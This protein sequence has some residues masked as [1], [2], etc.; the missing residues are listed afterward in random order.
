MRLLILMSSN[1]E[2]LIILIQITTV[3]FIRKKGVQLQNILVVELMILS[4]D[5]LNV[6]SVVARVAMGQDSSI[7]DGP[8][9]YKWQ[10]FPG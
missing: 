5:H 10:P 8:R 6:K 1:F 4:F 2:F 9:L 3:K 7:V